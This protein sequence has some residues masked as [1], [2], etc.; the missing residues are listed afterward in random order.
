VDGQAELVQLQAQPLQQE[1]AAAPVIAE[2]A[3]KAS[4][5]GG[6]EDAGLAVLRR[7]AGQGDLEHRVLARRRARLD[8]DGLNSATQ[9]APDLQP[10]FGREVRDEMQEI[11]RPRRAL[12]AAAERV[13]TD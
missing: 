8:D 9:A 1:R 2:R 13:A 12:S 10:P 4:S 5:A 7:A 3:D 6:D 11:M